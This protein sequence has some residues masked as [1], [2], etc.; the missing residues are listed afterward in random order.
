M[1]NLYDY[2]FELPKELIARYPLPE[3]QASRLLCLDRS[4]QTIRHRFFYQLPDLLQP[5]DLLVMN[6]TRVIPA[7][8]FAMKTT[9]GRVEILVERQ[10]VSNRVLAQLRASKTP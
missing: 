9:G 4:A 1:F 7:R 8:L 5:G 10:L 6:N 3:R 2:H